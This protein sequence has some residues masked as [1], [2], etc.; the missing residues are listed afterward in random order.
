MITLAGIAQLTAAHPAL[1][2][3]SVSTLVVTHPFVMMDVRK[4]VIVVTATTALIW[5][6]DKLDACRLARFLGVQK[7]MS[8]TNIRAIA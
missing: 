4:P 6:Q 3:I 1:R 2:E 8:A 5:K 7:D